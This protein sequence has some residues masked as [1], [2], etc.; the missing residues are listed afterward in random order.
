MFSLQIHRPQEVRDLLIAELWEAGVEGIVET[1]TGLRAFF[2]DEADREALAARFPDG[3]I[4]ETEHRDWVAEAREALQPMLV[5]ERFFLLPEWRDDPA[6]DGRV[7]IRINSGLAFGTGAHESTRLCLKALERLVQPR[8][9]VVDIG[10]GSGILAEAAKRLG[11]AR[12]IACDIDPTAVEVARENFSIA[13]LDIEV[14]EGS[15]QHVDS[16]LA[17]VLIGNI[18]PEWLAMLAKDF[19]RIV[20]PGG[21]VLLSGIE[22]TDLARLLPKLEAAGLGVERTDEENQWRA[23]TLAPGNTRLSKLVQSSERAAE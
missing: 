21:K 16:A 13:G 9:T 10:T 14:F 1:P 23:L 4:E 6:P 19:A 5:G 11:A 8:S 7:T 12:V 15:A 2:N 17:D 3:V 22:A 20:K 18:S